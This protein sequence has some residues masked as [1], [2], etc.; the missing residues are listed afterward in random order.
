MC[1]FAYYRSVL[2][3]GDLRIGP[4]SNPEPGEV[5]WFLIL[6]IWSNLLQNGVL[7]LIGSEIIVSKVS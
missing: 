4:E 5:P 3:G 1:A 2:P 7:C 6:I